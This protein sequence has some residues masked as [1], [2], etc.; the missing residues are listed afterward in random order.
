M[1]SIGV[2]L[3]GGTSAKRVSRS[4]WS[5]GFANRGCSSSTA[6][7]FSAPSACCHSR[8]FLIAGLLIQRRNRWRAERS[9]RESEERF[10]VMADTA[11]V[12][13]WRA[14][15]D[16]RCDFF[17]E[18]WLAFRGRRLQ[19][20]IGDGWTEGVHPDDLQR[21]L[22]VYTAAWPGRE[23]FRMEYRLRRADGE[24]RWVLDTGVPRL[25]SDGALLGYIGSCIDITERRQAE[26]ALRANEAAL[27]QS[28]AEIAHLAGRLI[29]AQ[30]AER[31][32]VARDL[33]DDISQK[34][35]AISIAM[36]ECRL[37]ELHASGDLLEVL[38]AVQRQTIELAEDIRL[39]SHDLHP[40]VLKHVGLLDA[41][42][43]HCADFARQQSIDV[44][45][46]ADAHISDLRY[47]R[48]RWVSTASSRR[49]CATSRNMPTPGTFTSPCGAS[50]KRCSSRWRTTGTGSPSRA[51][52]RW[53]PASVCAASKSGFGCWAG[54]LSIDTA[55]GMGTTVT[56]WIKSLVSSTRGF[57]EV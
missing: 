9:L 40:D 57:A 6:A 39:L 31:A 44:I 24:Y 55:P 34:L 1:R 50:R 3:T 46:E 22:T 54:A 28:H 19:D 2:S 25:G 15:P 4:A 38:S 49:R 10:R 7:T 33:H 11:P 32:R 26:E 29:T 23:S 51:R 36:S 12:M 30:E 37:P 53:A 14:G 16:Q 21:C 56:V 42:R 41:L 20:E 52:T 8:R 27:R 48:P 18:P 43:D 5:S 45:I 35:A 17:N 47:D 13:V